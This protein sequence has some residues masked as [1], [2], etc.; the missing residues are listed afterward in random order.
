MTPIRKARTWLHNFPN[1]TSSQKINKELC[2]SLSTIPVFVIETSILK[3]M[4][5]QNSASSVQ[6]NH[7]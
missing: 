1:P 3:L 4:G 7:H 6:D 5:E 2:S